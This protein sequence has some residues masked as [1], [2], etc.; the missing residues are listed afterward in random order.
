MARTGRVPARRR[1]LYRSCCSR[2]PSC[3]SPTSFE[4]YGTREHVHVSVLLAAFA[5]LSY[6]VF[7]SI[8]EDQRKVFFGELDRRKVR[9]RLAMRPLDRYLTE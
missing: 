3:S 1:V 5:G 2:S 8:F 7:A 6:T 9:Q 4:W